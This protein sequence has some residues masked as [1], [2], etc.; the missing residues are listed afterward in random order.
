MRQTLYDETVTRA[1]GEWVAGL[2]EWHVFGGLTYDP[3]RRF[4]DAATGDWVRPADHTVLHHARAWLRESERR[5][6]R[7]IEAAVVALEHHKSGWPHLHPLVRVA[8]GLLGN[9]FS[10]LGQTWFERHGY[11]RLEEP[12]DQL[13]VASYAAK[14]L[15]KDLARGDVLLW[16]LRGPLGTHQPQMSDPGTQP[17]V[18]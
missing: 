12:R 10:T 3:K 2:G 7:P 9:E 17:C 13:D 5:L 6:G 18:A 1:W 14:Y 11:A 16:P 15:M 4:T 8:G